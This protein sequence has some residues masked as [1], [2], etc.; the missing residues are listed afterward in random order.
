MVVGSYKTI[1]V[2]ALAALLAMAIAAG[3]ALAQASAQKPARLP[4]SRS[5]ASAP[6]RTGECAQ[7]PGGRAPVQKIAALTTALSPRD[8]DLVYFGK[9]LADLTDADFEQI[10]ALSKRCGQGEGILPA[11]KQEAFERIIREAQQARR[12]TLDKIKR[13]MAEITALPVARDKLTRLNG[14]TEN[15]P[16]LEPALT[17]GDVQYTA[18]W[19]A[20]QMQVV[21]DAA[22][23]GDLVAAS[24]P[25]PNRPAAAASSD[26]AAV[27]AAGGRVRSRGG[28][29]E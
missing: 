15:L 10:A 24:A 20:R 19:I 7:L 29:D 1:R 21:Y 13:Q 23:K 3:P 12:V 22:P 5:S 25:A 26:E 4:T 17:R 27:D 8:L 16:L 28:E 2:A 14:L 18:T 9:P 6:A 11:D